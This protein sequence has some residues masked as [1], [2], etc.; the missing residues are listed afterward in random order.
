MDINVL[1]RAGMDVLSRMDMNFPSSVNRGD[2][3]RFLTPA[4]DGDLEL[5]KRYVS[6]YDKGDG[7]AKTVEGIRDRMG[8]SAFHLAA[9]AGSLDI[10]KYFVEDLKLDVNL[11]DALD[12]TPLHHAIV[13]NRSRISVYLLENGANPSALAEKRLT[14]LHCAAYKGCIKVLELLISR[15]VEVDAQSDCGTPLQRAALNGKKEA[16]KILLA[17]NANPNAFQH[18]AFSPLTSAIEAGSVESVKLLLEA[19]ADPN[20]ESYGQTPI[21]A[22]T[23]KKGTEIIKCL[24]EAGANPNVTTQWGMTPLEI[25]ALNGDQKK[26]KIL[27]PVTSPIPHVT[28]WTLE[29]LMKYNC[30]EEAANQRKQKQKEQFLLL[31]SKGDDAFSTRKYDDAMFWY[32]RACELNPLDAAVFSNR[33]LCCALLNNGFFALENAKRCI[34][35]KPDWPE[36]YYREG[37]AWKLLKDF[38]KAAESFNTGLELDPENKELLL[39]Y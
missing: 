3:T 32:S 27:F 6:E 24:L 2:C 1:S 30:S 18:Q 9:T 21:E 28:N 4:W 26:A 38:P 36:A 29:G 10:C 15:G 34:S 12:K 17:N 37:V 35:L 25:A 33:S 11:K 22:A 20:N 23:Y 39:A 7:P 16:V 13:A 19:G 31:K 5:L 8:H 14:P